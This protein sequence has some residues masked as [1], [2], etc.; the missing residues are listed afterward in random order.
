ML[1]LVAGRG[2][3]KGGQITPEDGRCDRWVGGGRGVRDLILGR[4]GTHRV[5]TERLENLENE[6]GHGT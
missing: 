5:S 2:T 4:R 1:A 6:S 3:K